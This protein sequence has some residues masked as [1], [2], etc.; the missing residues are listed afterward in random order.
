MS[1]Y[2]SGSLLRIIGSEALPK[3]GVRRFKGLMTG[4]SLIDTLN[5]RVVIGITGTALGSMVML[6]TSR[7]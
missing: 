7:E 4:I 6:M 3:P 1:D 2:G 5:W